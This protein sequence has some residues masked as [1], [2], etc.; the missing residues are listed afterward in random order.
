MFL[1]IDKV[2]KE[3]TAALQ[4]DGSSLTYGELAEF[5]GKL[6]GIM[7]PSSLVFSLC[8][9]TIGAL[10]GYV[11]FLSA[12]VVPLLLSDRLDQELMTYLLET[13]QP[14]YLWVPAEQKQQFGGKSICERY[15]YV[16]LSFEREKKR[17]T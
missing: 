10:A 8:R 15:G 7:K 3:R 6:A 9:N 16:L 5:C 12:R 4:E 1:S 11:A 17:D 13:Y 14:D 2:K